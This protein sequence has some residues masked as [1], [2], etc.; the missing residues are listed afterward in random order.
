MYSGEVVRTVSR[1]TR[2]P[3][4]VIQDVI[5]ATQNVI[6][7]ELRGGRSVTFP[8]WGT[9]YASKRKAGKVRNIHTGKMADYPARKLPSFRAG[10]ELKRAVKGK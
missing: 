9:F 10:S 7:E 1:M 4:D 2:L 5:K 8:G 3:H 6:Q